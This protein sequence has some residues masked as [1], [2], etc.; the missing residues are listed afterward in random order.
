M[1]LQA[2]TRLG[3]YEVVSLIGAGGMGE[4]YRARDLRLGRD[5]ALKVL[6]QELGDEPARRQRFEQ[7]AKA[8]GALNHPNIVAVYDVGAENGLLYL[9]TELVDGEPLRRLLERG[10][11]RPRQ[12]A[13]LGA[14]AAEA[15]SMAHEVG[16]VHRDLKPENIMVTRDGRLKI[17]DFGLAR[18]MAPL[19]DGETISGSATQP[20]ML[21][22]T[23]SYMS[24]EQVRGEPVD[25]RSDIF[26]LGLV[27]HEALTGR[28]TYSRGSAAET[29]AAILREE[30][31]PLPPD[32][33]PALAL[34]IS[35]CLEKDRERRF[36]SAKDLAFGLRALTLPGDSVAAAADARS[37][38][39]GST[40]RRRLWALGVVC[41]LLAV[42]LVALVR[43]PRGVHLASYRYLPVA[44]EAGPERLGAWSPDGRSIAYIA[45]VEG[46]PQVFLRSLEAPQPV[47]ITRLPADRAADAPF[48][49]PDGSKIYF[50][51]RGEIWS[52]A[53]AGGEAQPVFPAPEAQSYVYAAGIS[54]DGSVLAAWRAR[55]ESGETR[56]TLWLSS[57]PGASMR[58]YQPAPFE[59]VGSFSPVVLRWAP[60]GAKL[61]VAFR[62]LDGPQLWWAPWPDGTVSP[63]RILD[64]F[65]PDT[66]LTFSWFPDSRRIAAAPFPREFTLNRKQGIWSVDTVTGEA[67]PITAGNV[68]EQFPAVSPD[69]TKLVY[70][71][72][73][74]DY[75]LVEIPVDGSQ[76][77]PLLASRRWEAWGAWSPVTQE[78]AYVTDK[79]GELEIVVR[80]QHSG[81]E[82]AVVRQKDFPNIRV[83][84]FM[85]PVFSPDGTRLAFAVREV[86]R[87]ASIWIVPAVG[88]VPVRQIIASEYAIAPTWSPDARWIAYLE[89][90]GGQD[91]LAKKEAA[92]NAP[93]V[94]IHAGGCIDAP[95]WSPAG[96]WIVCGQR[97]GLAI[98]SADGRMERRFGSEYSSM[99][100]WS[101]D[102]SLLYVVRS[103]GAERHFGTLHVAS[104][105]FQPISVLPR[106]YRLIAPNLM[107][108][109][110][111]LAPDGRSVATT[112][113]KVET[114]LWLLEG[115]NERPGWFSGLLW[116]PRASL[117]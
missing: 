27:L 66:V 106:E 99:A 45:H 108:R 110:F 61:L 13:D 20:G 95:A 55:R 102:G 101:R 47:Q 21:L 100:A 57:P 81:R 37:G 98:Y 94:V 84:R 26:S 24:P 70:T 87:L 115:F 86:G 50:L 90:R 48:W 65:A 97:E 17:L 69:G 109:T 105:R 56:S 2:G 73:G 15:L 91:V 54:P 4:V 92:T 32:L 79:R 89:S 34:I 39:R 46:V 59:A 51:S 14:Q 41:L 8:A 116:R 62:G 29:M 117:D 33:P 18:Q 43:R 9:V 22:G 67:T 40:G 1:R 6:P 80:H 85:N 103:R 82:A 77:R 12:V 88:G 64:Q 16:F 35:H 78:F 30:P 53:R 107:T 113:L 112:I 58:K 111:S 31:P 23:I 75:D 60:D 11:L 74:A 44:V 36:Q 83:S 19:E 7:E 5:V 49:A 72:G 10:P 114:D 76:P 104:G 63:R 38:R 93:G 96:D 25:H 71:A 3:P 52:V 42:L 28:G 68:P